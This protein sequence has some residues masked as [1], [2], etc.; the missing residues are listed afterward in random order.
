MLSSSGSSN[1]YVNGTF[2]VGRDKDMIV[3]AFYK[4]TV[5]DLFKNPIAG[6]TVI[7]NIKNIDYYRV[8]DENGVAQIKINLNRG[9]YE[10]KYKLVETSVYPESSSSNIIRVFNPSNLAS[11]LT[12]G[13]STNYDK[14]NTLFNFVRDEI[15][16]E[17]YSN[18]RYNIYEVLERESANCCDQSSLLVGLAR[19]IGLEIRYVHGNCKFSDGWYGHVWTEFYI[20]NQWLS[21]D[22]I[23]KRNS[24]GIINNWDTKTFILKAYYY[25]LPF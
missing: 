22:P 14:A 3:G 20:N 23:S 19:S 24:L 12:E 25:T 4:V 7:F 11:E 13:L 15:S 5:Y 18:S 10:I 2:I 21:G 8:T 9:D 6:E 17:E 16:Y 1:I